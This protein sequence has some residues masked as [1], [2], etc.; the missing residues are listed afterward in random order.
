MPS[1][2]VFIPT[3]KLFGTGSFQTFQDDSGICKSFYM[4]NKGGVLIL[5]ANDRKDR[6][7]KQDLIFTSDLQQLFQI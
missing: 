5:L 1:Q 4:Q 3:I 7:S 6:Q 2:S